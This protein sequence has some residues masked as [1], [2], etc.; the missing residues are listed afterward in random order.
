MIEISY[1]PL[2]LAIH[3][4]TWHTMSQ[5]NFYWIVSTSFTFLFISILF[6]VFRHWYYNQFYVI[7]FYN[8]ALITVP[9]YI[10]KHLPKATKHYINR[11]SSTD[12]KPHPWHFT[13]WGYFLSPVCFT[14]S[15]NY[16]RMKYAFILLHSTVCRM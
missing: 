6:V 9:F 12:D 7:L 11:I 2:V 5:L 14:G 8:V 16:P 1:F 3:C 13:T 4:I 15:T 10:T